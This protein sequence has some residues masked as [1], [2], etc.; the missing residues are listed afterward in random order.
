MR[1]ALNEHEK[2]RQ[3]ESASGPSPPAER[4]RTLGNDRPRAM[5]SV[6]NLAVLLPADWTE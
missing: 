4:R 2:F 6:N 5:Q 1:G 3:A